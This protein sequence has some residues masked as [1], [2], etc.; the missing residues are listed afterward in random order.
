FAPAPTAN[1]G[2]SWWRAAFARLS[3]SCTLLDWLDKNGARAGPA[4]DHAIERPEE[5]HARHSRSSALARTESRRERRIRQVQA[6]ADALRP[7]H[8]GRGRAGLSWHRGS[9]RTGPAARALEAARRPRLVYPAFR[10]RGIVGPLPRRNPGRRRAQRGAA[11]LRKGRAGGRRPRHD[12]GLAGR[13]GQA[14]R[15]RMA[16]GLAVLDPA[17]RLPP[18]RE[19]GQRTRAALV[20]DL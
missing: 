14:A 12:R 6:R 16:E 15:V 7:L 1:R 9:P 11:P 19:C 17:Q 8:G 3:S 13:T 4:T 10:H 5:T 20:R 2:R 18:A